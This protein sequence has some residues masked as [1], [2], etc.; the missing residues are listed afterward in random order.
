MYSTCFG[1]F[2]RQCKHTWKFESPPSVPPFLSVL[3]SFVG[4]SLSLSLRS[5]WPYAGITS[6]D[7]C[8]MRMPL[9][10]LS[11][12]RV[13]SLGSS[14]S[15][16]VGRSVGQTLPPPDTPR[17]ERAPSCTPLEFEIPTSFFDHLSKSSTIYRSISVINADAK[18]G[19][20]EKEN[21]QFDG[22][23]PFDSVLRN[24]FFLHL[25]LA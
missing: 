13:A 22:I 14:A 11:A 3:R 19:L 23:R 10:T 12:R 25:I 2:P 8:R 15:V 17:R 9:A 4:V 18:L 1:R 21:E 16:S 24:G 5:T 6:Y 20:R 7:S